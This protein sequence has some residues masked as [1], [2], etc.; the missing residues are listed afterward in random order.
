MWH[1]TYL[2]ILV[3]MERSRCGAHGLVF[4]DVHEEALF[5]I[6]KLNIK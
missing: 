3:G 4:I 2:A 5:H 1:T 6:E